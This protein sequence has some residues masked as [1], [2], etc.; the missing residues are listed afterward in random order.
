MS[1]K[2]AFFQK[3]DE[4]NKAKR[5]AD[6]AFKNEVLAFQNDTASLIAEIKGWFNHTSIDATSS[7][8]RISE[9]TEQFEVPTLI[10]R[11]GDKILTIEPEGFY[12]FGATGNLNV[13]IKSVSSQSR[14]PAFQLHWKDSQGNQEGWTIVAGAPLVTRTKFTQ[15]NF[16]SLIQSFA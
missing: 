11:N 5:E 2:D 15:D 12:Y 9:G 14:Q 7:Q 10:L 1:A 13:T 4:N 8:M 6:E 3:L 16:F